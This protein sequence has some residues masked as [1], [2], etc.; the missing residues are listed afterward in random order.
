MQAHLNQLSE[1]NSSETFAKKQL[2][3]AA[4]AQAQTNATL[5]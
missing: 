2:A 1:T 4:A 5:L 3:K